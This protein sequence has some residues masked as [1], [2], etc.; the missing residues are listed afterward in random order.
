MAFAIARGLVVTQMRLVPD[1]TL[2]EINAAGCARR[3]RARTAASGTSSSGSIQ[4]TNSPLRRPTQTWRYLA[5][6]AT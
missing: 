3:S 2:L 5:R 1:K 6:K 4:S